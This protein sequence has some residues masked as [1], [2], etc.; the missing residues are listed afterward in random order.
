[1]NFPC[2]QCVHYHTHFKTVHGKQVALQYGWCSLKS[3]YPTVDRDG[4][5]AP[6]GAVRAPEGELAKPYIVWKD[7]VQLHCVQGIKSAA[8]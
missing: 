6:E 8:S 2:G 1:M 7:R 3:I 4:Q 5:R